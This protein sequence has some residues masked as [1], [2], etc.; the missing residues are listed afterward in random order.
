MRLR[1]TATLSE[2]MRMKSD[3]LE[4]EISEQQM[5]DWF[6][7]VNKGSGMFLM[8]SILNFVKDYSFV[9]QK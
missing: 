1:C 4:A 3:P 8:I 5:S 7:D 2:V 9:R 6:F